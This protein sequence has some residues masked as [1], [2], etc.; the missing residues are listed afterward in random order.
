MGIMTAR[1]RRKINHISR[2]ITTVATAYEDLR[3]AAVN[4]PYASARE[5][6]DN[7]ASLL[8]ELR[9]NRQAL[10]EAVSEDFGHRPRQETDMAELYVVETEI[11]FAHRALS[12]WMARRHK[13][14]ALQWLPGQSFILPQPLGVVAILSPWNYPIQLSL[15][16]L[17]SALAAGNRVL[18]KVSEHT[19]ATSN[20][21]QKILEDIFPTELVTVVQGGAE[22][23]QAV[24][25]L[26][27]DHIFFT[28]ST[29]VGRA[30]ALSAAKNLVPITLELGGKS[31]AIIDVTAN[32]NEAA[33][34]IAHGKLLNSGQTCVAPDYV[35]VQENQEASFIK[36][37]VVAAR[38]MYSSRGSADM[39][40]LLGQSRRE[41]LKSMMLEASD[42]GAEIIHLFEPANF[43]THAIIRNL[44]STCRL[45]EEEIFGPVLPIITYRD[46]DDMLRIIGKSPDPLA[47]Y[48][49]GSNSERR[50]AILREVRSGG[51]TVNGTLWHMVQHGLPFGGVGTSGQGA[52]HG[53]AGFDRFSHLKSVFV[54]R[55]L[56]GS[57]LLRPP[58]GT[59]F[60]LMM[61]MLRAIS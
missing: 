33:A 10:V 39:A 54:E 41:R 61:K 57:S 13:I 15:V 43:P 53:Q 12:S 24:C 27:L 36:A 44:P 40:S 60:D 28:G 59:P 20:L 7:L 58:F 38:K 34:R 22:V 25:S 47:L 55:G 49:F 35:L 56:T 29:S 42:G 18:L 48:W 37:Y 23:A 46:Y 14:T 11:R 30:V 9:T 3:A 50:N 21:L 52:Y 45:I 2:P 4:N 17:V 51:V 31:P 26:P 6:K 16:P 32:I 19:P 1:S 5:R 8:G